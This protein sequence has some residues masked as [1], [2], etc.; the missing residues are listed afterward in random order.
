MAQWVD[1]EESI[2]KSRWAQFS[3]QARPELWVEL[4]PGYEDPDDDRLER[5]YA[6]IAWRH[7]GEYNYGKPIITPPGSSWRPASPIWTAPIAM[8]ACRA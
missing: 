3:N 5:T 4:G 6:K 2:S 7:Q 1:S 8:L